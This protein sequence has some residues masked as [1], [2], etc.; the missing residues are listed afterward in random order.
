MV[1]QQPFSWYGYE[2]FADQYKRILP[3]GIHRHLKNT[4]KLTTVD[5]KADRVLTH[6]QRTGWISNVAKVA[7]QG[8]GFKVDQYKYVR[9]RI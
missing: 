5:S 7:R 6:T 9:A 3:R 2:A 1:S 4:V 8:L